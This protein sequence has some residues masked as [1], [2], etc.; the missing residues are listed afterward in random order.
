[1][2]L[3][4]ASAL[5]LAS[6]IVAVGGPAP[7]AAAGGPAIVRA[8]D[9]DPSTR[10]ERSGVASIMCEI[11][12]PLVIRPAVRGP[13]HRGAVSYP[14]VAE[15]ITTE[16]DERQRF[17]GGPFRACYRWARWAKPQLS[18]DVTFGIRVDE[19]GRIDRA[20]A[21]TDAVD[22]DLAA[23][24]SHALTGMR[25]GLYTPR[26][27]TLSVTFRLLQSGQAR[28]PRRPAPPSR[29]PRASGGQRVCVEQPAVLPVDRLDEPVP[30]IVVDDFSKEQDRD[31]KRAAYHAAMKAWIA[32]G[33][34][35]PEPRLEPEVV[36]CYARV[37]GKPNRPDV[38]AS[39]SF[40]RGDFEACYAEAAARGHGAGGD[41][42]LT[43]F[44][45]RAG[46][47]QETRARS[48]TTRDA[49][50]DR[51]LAAALAHAHVATG[52]GG[53]FEVHVP[54]RLSPDAAGNAAANADA[55]ERSGDAVDRG[56]GANA[57]A[58]Y[59]DALAAAPAPR[60]CAV[61]VGLLQA[62][63]TAAPWQEDERVSAAVDGVRD[64]MRAAP[65]SALATCQK[66]ALPILTAWVARPFELGGATRRP[67]IISK[68]ADR[69]RRLLAFEPALPDAG[70][71]RVLR[72][73]ALLRS[74]RWRE[75][76]DQLLSAARGG[77]IPAAWA[78]EAANAAA[79]AY[80]RAL[81]DPAVPDEIDRVLRLGPSPEALERHPEIAAP[82]RAA[83]TLRKPDPDHPGGPWERGFGVFHRATTTERAAALQGVP[84]DPAIAAM[85]PRD[86]WMFLRSLRIAGHPELVCHEARRAAAASL[87]KTDADRA[88]LQGFLES[89]RPERDG[90][91]AALPAT[92]PTAPLPIQ[93][94]GR[95]GSR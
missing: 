65:A 33:R 85:A 29:P 95:R 92:D 23:C 10:A 82:L 63:L 58:R 21:A 54:L 49:T 12:E 71:L 5:S 39:I 3:A 25:V 55:E 35:G 80:A 26:E 66:L 52:L 7:I 69:M 45:N 40:Q 8:C 22:R 2:P 11:E 32:D 94:V 4:P 83:L 75:A 93:Q 37:R 28:L 79:W 84:A 16:L 89:C 73:E 27:T 42:A 47:F 77:G 68:A 90:A 1:V 86:G 62:A 50:L 34:H 44:V 59:Q 20:A 87:A 48:S 51:C 53:L 31:E 74:S 15:E 56:D 19:W 18:G 14:R 64:A 76:A 91:P 13:R 9:P 46:Q 60:R 61:T 78:E 36:P 41:V 88:R 57:W 67:E 72:G 38:A 30:V 6:A 70:L 43:A 81:M 24:F 17:D